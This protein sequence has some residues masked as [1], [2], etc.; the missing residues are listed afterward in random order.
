MV[1]CAISLVHPILLIV[2]GGQLVATKLHAL[3][4]LGLPSVH[5][6]RSHERDVHAEIAMHGC[7][8]IA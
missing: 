5:L 6:Q 2:S 4:F 8:L 3:E 1:R 7:A